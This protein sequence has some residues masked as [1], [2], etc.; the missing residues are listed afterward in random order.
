MKAGLRLIGI[1]PGDLGLMTVNA[2]E[3]AKESDHRFLEGYTATLPSD[4]E[5]MLEDRIGPWTK[6]MRPEIEKPDGLLQLA[7]S[8]EAG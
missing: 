6:L 5:D 7:H 3:A 4:Q 2:I 1:G 8:L